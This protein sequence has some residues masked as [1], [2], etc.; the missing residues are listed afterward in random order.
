MRNDLRVFC[1]QIKHD[2][3]KRIYKEKTNLKK[4]SFCALE[5][6]LVLREM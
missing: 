2:R 4:E 6:V 3:D 1:V 5:Q